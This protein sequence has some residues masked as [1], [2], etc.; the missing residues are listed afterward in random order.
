MANHKVIA[1]TSPP[2]DISHFLPPE[3]E[4]GPCMKALL[5]RQQLF[6]LAM[7]DCGAKVN[8]TAAARM[9]GFLGDT[10]TLKVQGHRLAHS[11]KVQAA[12]LEEAQKRLQSATMVATALLQDVVGNPKVP[13]KS[14]LVAAGM[15]LDRGGLHAKSEHKV[16]VSHTDNRADKILRV[17]ELARLTGQDP[18]KLLGSLADV[19]DAEIIESTVPRE[20]SGA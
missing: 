11:Q 10:N 4:L 12:I 9:A 3:A 20:T 7:L 16:Q 8:H 18:Q 6:V 17:V 2:R 5:P 13:V 15:I 14:R 19:T 1:N